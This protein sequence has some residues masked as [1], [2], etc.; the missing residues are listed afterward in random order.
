MPRNN[1][2]IELIGKLELKLCGMPEDSLLPTEQLLA[3]EFGVSKPTLRR[4]LQSL[5]DAG[6]VRKI[7]GVGSFISK[8]P[9]SISRELLFICHDIVF[10]AE[11]LNS[12]GI[13]AAQSNY[14]ISIVPLAG[15]V[16]IQERII[17]SAAERHPAGIAVYADPKQSK[18][19]AFDEL[20][21]ANIPLLYLMR[22]PHGIDNN[23]IEFG[24]ADGINE[25]I[26]RFYMDG[27]RRIALYGDELVNPIAAVERENGFKSGMRQCR[28]KPRP[29]LLAPYSLTPELREKFLLLFNDA[30]NRPDAVCCLNDHCAGRLIKTLM[31]RGIDLNNIRFSGFDHSPLSEFIP[32]SLLTVEPPMKELGKEAAEILIKQVENPHFGFQRKK[33]K[34][35]IIKTK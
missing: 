2:Y 28:L 35:Q 29:E 20:A 23:L 17:T 34:A 1:T 25:I 30:E 3:E 27:C 8:K 22:L 31:Q 10:F 7:N 9:R 24:N 18:L 32:I 12:F 16:S 5:V 14:F 33:L 11:A 13:Y 4:A 15:D 26:R 6:Q 19:M 21:T